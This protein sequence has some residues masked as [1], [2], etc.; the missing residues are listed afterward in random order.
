[1]RIHIT[2][3]SGSGAT[4]LG[5]ALSRTLSSRHLDSD[6]YYWLPTQPPYRQKRLPFERLN[7]LKADIQAQENVVVSG[8]L[9]GWGEEIENAFDL[10]V[11]LYLPASIRLARLSQREISLYGAVDP[12]FLTWA[13]QYDEG[14]AEGRSLARH[15]AWLAQRLCPVLRLEKDLSVAER[16]ANVIGAISHITKQKTAIDGSFI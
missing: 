12:A 8:S 16:I 4:T 2:G 10:I 7:L 15:N 9:V 1:M 11:F 6:H 13:S 3:A 14:T 5:H